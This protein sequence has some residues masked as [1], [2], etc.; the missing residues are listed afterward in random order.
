LAASPK[1]IKT[2]SPASATLQAPQDSFGRS[3][4]GWLMPAHVAIIFI[5]YLLLKA[6]HAMPA[7]E[8]MG[9]VRALFS[10]VNAAT[11]TG[12]QQPADIDKYLPLGQATIFSLIVIGTIFSFVIGGLAG[13]RILR[14]RYTDARVNVSA[15]IL[16]AGA[17]G[18]GTLLLLFDKDRTVWQAIFV[19]ASAIGNCGLTIGILPTMTGWE[20]H[21]VLLPLM[22]IGGFGLPVIMELFDAITGRSRLS[23]YSK[24]ALGL[25]AWSFI[26]ATILLFAARSW[27]GN[28]P[29][30]T[31]YRGQQIRELL[32]ASA[33]GAINTR[34]AG[35]ALEDLTRLSRIVIWSMIGLMAIGAA[36]AGSAGGIKT[37]TLFEIF[38]GVRRALSNQ[39]PGRL[40]GIALVWLAAYCLTATI[41]LLL[42][43]QKLPETPPEKILFNVIS[44]LSNVGLSHER[45]TLD[46]F[47]GYV[48]S[49]T[50]LIGRL[51]PLTILWWI[52]DTAPDADSLVG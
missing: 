6:P 49:V 38:R 27:A 36:S 35:M 44:A 42:L 18:V 50:M 19:S 43:L 8:E 46:P 23:R 1:T 14:Q 41:A 10:S 5:G 40:F 24:T 4:V 12:F 22:A 20:T 48:L 3:L 34:T 11:L 21:L 39:P 28:Y 9:S 45:L 51:G 31:P 25:A 16:E 15:L 37:T 33:A 7:G 17:I 30:D 13:T 47:Y 2:N 52:V 26:G 32:A 29:S